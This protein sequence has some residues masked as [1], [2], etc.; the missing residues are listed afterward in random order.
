M[1]SEMSINWLVSTFGATGAV[2]A[3]VLSEIHWIRS[4]E[5]WSRQS[6]LPS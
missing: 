4:F 1:I 5:S 3:I 6:T 2:C